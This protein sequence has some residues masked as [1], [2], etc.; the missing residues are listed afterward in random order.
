MY[1]YMFSVLVVAM[2]VFSFTSVSY[3]RELN[4]GEVNTIIYLLKAY[5]FDDLKIQQIRTIIEPIELTDCGL[6]DK[7]SRLTGKPCSE[8]VIIPPTPTETGTGTTAQPTP[9]EPSTACHSNLC[10]PLVTA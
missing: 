2:L 4:S 6:G 7:F 10:V 3:A 1:K 8:R 5:N 9:Y